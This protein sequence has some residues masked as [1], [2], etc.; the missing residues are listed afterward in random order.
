M[1]T[2]TSSS[3]SGDNGGGDEGGGWDAYGNGVMRSSAVGSAWK[4]AKEESLSMRDA[5]SRLLRR[6]HLRRILHAARRLFLE[7]TNQRMHTVTVYYSAGSTCPNHGHKDHLQIRQD[8][9]R[10]GILIA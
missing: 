8:K 2:T 10:V 3:S 6:A 5:Q 1:A 4:Q 7:R 9:K